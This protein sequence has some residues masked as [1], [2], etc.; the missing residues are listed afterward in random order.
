MVVVLPP[1]NGIATVVVVASVDGG[2]TVVVIGAEGGC[3][4]YLHE[5]D[6]G[7]VSGFVEKLEVGKLTGIHSAAQNH[8]SG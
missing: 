2:R 6:L 4:S 3:V 5:K 7:I 1:G 8:S